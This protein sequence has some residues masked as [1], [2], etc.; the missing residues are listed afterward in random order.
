MLRNNEATSH[1]A[2]VFISS[3]GSTNLSGTKF[4]E[5]SGGARGTLFITGGG[6]VDFRDVEMID[7]INMNGNFAGGLIVRCPPIV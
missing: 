5:N 1:G 7:N 6:N 4:V 2:A 3:M